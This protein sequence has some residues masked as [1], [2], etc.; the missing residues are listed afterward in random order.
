MHRRSK[1]QFRMH[2]GCQDFLTQLFRTW[3][4]FMERCRSEA[5]SCL[6]P[7]AQSLTQRAKPLVER[8]HVA[9]LSVTFSPSPPATVVVVVAV[10][11]GR[12]RRRRR[13][14]CFDRACCLRETTMVF[15]RSSPSARSLSR[16]VSRHLREGPALNRA[17]LQCQQAQTREHSRIWTK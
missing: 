15:K 17:A 2:A 14:Q 4:P 16:P 10:V 5:L 11:G 6:G 3:S 12:R 8:P 1:S 9:L 13:R 7:S